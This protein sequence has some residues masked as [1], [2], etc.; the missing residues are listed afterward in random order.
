MTAGQLS[1]HVVRDGD[2]IDGIVDRY[3]LSSRAAL[4]KIPA[5]QPLKSHFAERGPLPDGLLVYIPPRAV[6]LA[7]DRVYCL[8]SVRPRVIAHFDDCR[9][10]LANEL[11]PAILGEEA[12]GEAGVV[13]ELLSALGAAAIE[14]I[15]SV[16]RSMQPLVPVCQALVL[17]HVA[18]ETDHAVVGAA[19]DP[20][21]PL[22]WCITPPILNFW[23]GFWE[24][25]V[26]QEKWLGTSAEEAF[27]LLERQ[28]NT[29]SSLVVQRFDQRIRDSQALENRLRFEGNS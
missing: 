6:L 23:S 17:T 3:G 16:S 29:L 22:Y 18:E 7:R 20:L 4:T 28:L 10:R 24:P 13:Q 21:C 5:N 2:T 14:T 9:E 25:P 26:W 27:R 11:G 12:P 1:A 19:E 15:E 8:Q